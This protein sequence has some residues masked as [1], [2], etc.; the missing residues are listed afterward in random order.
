LLVAHGAEVNA[1]DS[2]GR[3]PMSYVYG[4]QDIKELLRRHGGHE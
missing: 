3:T 1:K 2:A 4:F